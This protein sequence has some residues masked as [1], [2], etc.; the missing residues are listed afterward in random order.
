MSNGGATPVWNITGSPCFCQCL[1]FLPVFMPALMKFQTTFS[2]A[3][4]AV[5]RRRLDGL[6]ELGVP[7]APA[8]L[9]DHVVV[10]DLHD[11]LFD[12]LEGLVGAQLPAGQL[13]LHR[14]GVGGVPGVH[15]EDDVRLADPLEGLVASGQPGLVAAEE[16]GLGDARAAAGEGDDVRVDRDLRGGL[17]G[18][19]AI[20]L[21]ERVH[22]SSSPYT[23]QRSTYSPSLKVSMKMLPRLSTTMSSAVPIR[24]PGKRSPVLLLNS[25]SGGSGGMK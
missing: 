11:L 23:V 5:P 9:Q 4:L 25:H 3:D 15:G 10:G 24:G 21:L 16:L 14:L 6:H 19:G 2:V 1:M 8:L 20:Q 18:Y 13:D 7:G 12:E 17:E 22:R